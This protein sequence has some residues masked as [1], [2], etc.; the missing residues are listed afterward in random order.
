MN[1]PHE[2]WLHGP[3]GQCKLVSSHDTRDEAD[4]RCAELNT[5]ER[6]QSSGVHF[7][8]DS[9]GDLTPI[10]SICHN[11]HDP[12][13]GV[14]VILYRMSGDDQVWAA[15]EGEEPHRTDVNVGGESTAWGGPQWDLQI[16]E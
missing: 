13:E 3:S 15:A 12:D 6:G 14:R 4:Q 2:V 5:A 10:G 8:V 9:R 16:A 11:D 7:V 1:M